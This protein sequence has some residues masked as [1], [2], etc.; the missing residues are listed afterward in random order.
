MVAKAKAL[1]EAVM[2][3]PGSSGNEGGPSED[4]SE[5]ETDHKPRITASKTTLRGAESV[6]DSA[7]VITQVDDPF[8]DDKA[9]GAK[10][11][12]PPG[13]VELA[14]SGTVPADSSHQN[15]ISDKSNEAKQQPRLD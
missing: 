13:D 6:K 9:E 14:D 1:N 11:S 15:E 4:V 8:T 3:R 7:S 12:G 10:S 2:D 5:N